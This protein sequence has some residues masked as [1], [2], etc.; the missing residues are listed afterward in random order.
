MTKLDKQGWETQTRSL[1][2]NPVS[3]YLQKMYRLPLE[4]KVEAKNH[5]NLNDSLIFQQR[6]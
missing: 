4:R 5:N 6:R 3:I 2:Q 1:L